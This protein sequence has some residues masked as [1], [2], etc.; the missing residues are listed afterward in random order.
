MSKT[1]QEDHN[2]LFDNLKNALNTDM[3]TMAVEANGGRSILFVY[4][5][6]EDDEYIEEGK[7]RLPSEQFEFVDI[8]DTLVDFVNSIG[9]DTFKEILENFGKE[10]YRSDNTS[11]GTF[12]EFLMN[13][14]VNAYQ[15]GKSPVLIHTG[16]LYGM[17]ISNIHIM[18][19]ERVMYAKRQL[20]VFYP[21]SV[22]GET[23]KFMGIHPASHYRCIVIK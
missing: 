7:K 8:R 22:E 4:P 10:I 9:H 16:A 15:N 21:A 18:E 3:A 11:K 6:E 19:D 13:K 17:E 14:I 20:V 2:R 12:F 1:F 5:F 23:I